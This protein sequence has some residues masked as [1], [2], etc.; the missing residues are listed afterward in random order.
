MSDKEFMWALKNGDLDEVKDYVGKVR[1]GTGE[2]VNRT[3]EGG[4]KPLHYATDCGQLEI[5]EFLLL[6]GADINAPDKHNITPLLSAVYEGHVSCVKLLLSKG[7]DKTVRG[8][9]GLTAFEATDNQA[10]KA[11][12]Q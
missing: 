2:D 8:P 10:I 12:L 6:K 11:L 5:L 9:D 1:P 4:R 3:L 7:A